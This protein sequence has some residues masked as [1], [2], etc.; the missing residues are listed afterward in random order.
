[1]NNKKQITIIGATGNLGCRVTKNLIKSGYEVTAIVRNSEK[2]EQLF[3]NSPGIKILTADLKDVS[4]LR[5]ALNSTAFLY[6]NLSTQ[7]TTENI[8]FAPDREGIA[9]ILK[10]V[11]RD[12]IK[13]ILCISGMGALD[14]IQAPGNKPFIPNLIRKQG[15][16]LLKES[17]IPYT[18]LHCSWFLDSFII[19]E[20]N[21]TYSI[22]GD[23]ENQIYFTNCYDFSQH[24]DMAIGNP[25]AYYK[26]FPIQGF[27]GL[28]H[29]DAA[30]MFFDVYDKEFK[31]NKLPVGIIRMMSVFKKEF[32]YLKHMSDYFSKL[33][34][35][36]LAND[37]MTWEILGKP[38]TGVREYALLLKNEEK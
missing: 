21:K 5:K 36:F 23:T 18:I 10:A 33:K 12:I 13:Q 28:K 32:K 7:S 26:E 2:A 31:I 1:M 8:P 20:R 22:I 35:T 3:K 11:N 25:E 4:A 19:F 34:E 16:K 9:N 24:I 37:F 17:G 30:R 14:N 38:T 6:L 29:P 27:E 15:H